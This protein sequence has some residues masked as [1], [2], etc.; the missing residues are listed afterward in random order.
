VRER[1]AQKPRVE[2]MTKPEPDGKYRY[3][4]SGSVESIS[5]KGSPYYKANRTP[6][7]IQWS[8]VFWLAV[9]AAVCAW[10]MFEMV[11]GG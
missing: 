7:D 1:Y 4:L 5:S 6:R 2:G 3:T 11:V 9:G 8:I 10:A